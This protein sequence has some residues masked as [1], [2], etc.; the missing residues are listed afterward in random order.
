MVADNV[1][2]VKDAP[3]VPSVAVII[4]ARNE[5]ANLGACLSSVHQALAQA[6]VAAELVVVD[7]DS[8]DETSAV[9]IAGGAAVLRQQPRRGPLAAW[10]L[11]VESTSAPFLILVDADCRVDRAAF[12]ALL[13]RFEQ[14][15]V[16]VVAGRSQ[17]TTSGVPTG[18]VGRSANFS[19]GLLHRIKTRLDDHDFLPIGRLMAVRR[20]AWQVSDCN[21][22]PCDRAVAHLARAAGWGIVYAPGA[23]VFYEPV[24]TYGALEDDYVRTRAIGGP[25]PLR[26]DRLPLEVLVRAAWAEAIAAPID[27]LAWAICRVLLL[28]KRRARSGRPTISSW[29]G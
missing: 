7:D 18:M 20:A 27:A 4:P 21:L 29:P 24:A 25:A 6:Q 1:S 23:L 14:V 2:A 28:G 9:A 16:G 19:S 13:P 17:P 12:S 8:T 3:T 22:V 5:A 26:Y 10:M 11:G 15:G